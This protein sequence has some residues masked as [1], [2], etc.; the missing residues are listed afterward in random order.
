MAAITA[1]RA[2]ADQPGTHLDHPTPSTRVVLLD[3]APRLGAKI[4]AAGGGRCNVTHF[5]VKPED[6]C[7]TSRHS[8]RKVMSRFPVEETIGFFRALGVELKREDTGKLFPVTDKARTVLEALLREA[9]ALGVN[10]QVNHRVQAVEKNDGGFALS[11]PFGRLAAKKI[12]LA[13]GGKSLPTTGSDG[14]GY[15]LAQSLGH[16]LTP[17]IFPALVPLVLA[18]DHFIRS[19]SGITLPTTLEVRAGSGKRIAA[20]TDSTLCTHFGLSGPCALNISRFLTEALAE[21]PAAK[22]WIRWLPGAAPESLDADLQ[23]LGPGSPLGYLRGKLPERLALALCQA[24]GIDPKTP[25]HRLGKADRKNLVRALTDMPLPVIGDKGYNVA[26][27]TAGGI[28]LTEIDLKTMESRLCPGLYLCGEICDVDGR[29]GGFN[30]QWAW[31]SGYVAGGAAA[32]LVP[33]WS[34]T[35]G[36]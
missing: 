20:F 7:G 22:L 17:R 9:A 12:I 23:N 8:I 33:V 3:G 34:G 36:R 25:G 29:I 31:A 18:E 1:G 24:A 27:V 16:G 5:E 13:T 30:F 15:A 21:D 4:L 32:G 11:G 26:E 19:I 6:F 35:A 10:I 2:L 14:W 28:P